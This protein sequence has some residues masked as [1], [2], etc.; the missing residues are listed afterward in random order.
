MNNISIPI[1][2]RGD[3]DR[4]KT[5]LLRETLHHRQLQ[6]SLINGGEYKQIYAELKDLINTHVNIGWPNTHFLSFSEREEK[7][8]R[9]GLHLGSNEDLP[10]VYIDYNG[11]KNGFALIKFDP[12]CCIIETT[13]D[14]GVYKC[15]YKPRLT[16][17]SNYK[18]FEIILIDVVKCIEKKGFDIP[19]ALEYAKRDAE[20]LILPITKQCIDGFY[21]TRENTAILDM[22]HDIFTFQWIDKHLTISSDS[23]NF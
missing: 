23:S 1:L 10:E 20:W 13:L 17:Y 12:E 16:D 15:S 11:S 19:K 3:A 4:K 9:Y 21:R 5:R 14:I 2:Y 8:M 22:G 6:T 18:Y 7:A